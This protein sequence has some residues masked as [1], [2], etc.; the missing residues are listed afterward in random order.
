MSKFEVEVKTIA[1]V[2][3]HSNAD[4]LTIYKAEG[5]AYQFISNVKYEVGDKVVF[6]PIDSVMPD[7]LI[8]LFGLG[9]MLSGKKHNRVKTVKLRGSVSQG[10]IADVNTVSEHLGENAETAENL[11]EKLGITKY[12]PPEVPCHNGNLVSL[13]AG[14]S[15]YDIE[16]ADN[17]PDVIQWIIDNQ[18]RVA[19]TEKLEGQNFS[20]TIDQ[21]GEIHVNQRRFSIK[22]KEGGE[23]DFWKVAR[24]EGIID[25]V[26]SLKSEHGF[27]DL[28]IYGEHIGPSIQKNHYGL[29]NKTVRFFDMK[30][31]GSFI[32]T[33][34]VLQFLDDH[35]MKDSYV[36]ILGYDV[37]LDEWLEGKSINEASYGKSALNDKVLRE[38]IVIKPMKEMLPPNSK[39][40]SRLIIKQ[41]DPVYLEKTGH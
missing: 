14:L 39:L 41:R 31:N 6:F 18:I 33:T 17:Y 34:D 37:L 11:T 7:D 5:M 1:E 15:M 20:V 38:G 28:T 10:F 19:I 21:N 2:I 13:P 30:S 24:K 9:K 12:E 40:G 36:P 35:D 32:D 16:G 8:E 23:H 25:L 4:R 22:E 3:P 27:N 29:S 26:R